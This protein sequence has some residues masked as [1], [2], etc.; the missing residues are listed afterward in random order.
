MVTPSGGKLWRLNI[1]LKARK[2]R[3][4]FGSY[5]EISLLDARRNEMMLEGS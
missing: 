2:K 3:L 1:D 5:P 4:A